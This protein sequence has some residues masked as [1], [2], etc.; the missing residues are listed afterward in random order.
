MKSGALPTALLSA[1]IALAACLGGGCAQQGMSS[2]PSQQEANRRALQSRAQAE[3]QAKAQAKRMEDML[4]KTRK[5]ANA[6]AAAAP[7]AKAEQD[8]KTQKA[9]A[10]AT[11]M[12]EANAKKRTD[13]KTKADEGP[14]ADA[15][16]TAKKE[17]AARAA[18]KAN[19]AALAE[20]RTGI[21]KA[22]EA[23]RAGKIADARQTVDAVKAMNADLGWWDKLDL[24][25]LEGQVARAEAAQ[26]KAPP[27]PDAEKPPEKS[28]DPGK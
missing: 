26:A 9:L 25:N 5:E 28:P 16:A 23:L 6:K 10:E 11:A 2:Q 7:K 14:D 20:A 12:A 17:S 4:A 27:K 3:A 19:A 21:A 22:K 8:A 15:Q 13:A 1:A 18:A 24:A